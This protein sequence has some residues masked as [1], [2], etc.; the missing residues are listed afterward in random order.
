QKRKNSIEARLKKL[1]E[2]SRVEA[3][4]ILIEAKDRAVKTL[5]DAKFEEKERMV[6]LRKNEDRLIRREESLDKK[7]ISLDEKEK[8]HKENIDRVKG[9]KVEIEEMK[10]KVLKELERVAD[11][12]Q[13]QAREEIFK[14]LEKE[15]GD[16]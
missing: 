12:S 4:E 8:E 16:E 11:L 3:K 5:E 7:L 10:Q 13:V 1:I 2:D 14:K 15:N 9:I 6:E